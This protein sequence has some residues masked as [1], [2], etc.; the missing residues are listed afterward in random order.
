MINF[1]NKSIPIEEIKV[2]MT[3]SYSQTITDY[4]IKIFAGLSGDHNPIHVSNDYI[5]SSRFK[6]RVAHGFIAAS[7]F[8]G[9]FGTKLPGPGCLYVSQTLNFKKPIYV[10]DDIIAEAEVIEVS[11]IS[12][13]VKFKTIVKVN[14]KIAID[15]TAELFIPKSV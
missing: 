1:N 13:H 12:R 5:K 11:I 3:V 4:D 15:G 9:M 10:D 7:F 6:K 14:N 8:S 2:G